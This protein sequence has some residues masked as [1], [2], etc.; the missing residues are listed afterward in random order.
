[1]KKVLSF[2][3][4][5]IRGAVK[6]L[7]FGNAAI[8]IGTSVK[9]FVVNKQSGLAKPATHDWKS[10]ITQVVVLGLIIYAFASG[11]ITIEQALAWLGVK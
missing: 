11:T 3:K 2:V 1:M 6:S 10:I 4:P 5:F 9:E 8:E 7:P